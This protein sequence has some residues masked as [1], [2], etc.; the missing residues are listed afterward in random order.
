MKEKIKTFWEDL[1][2]FKKRNVIIVL[3]FLIP[4]III[5]ATI[6]LSP[7]LNDPKPSSSLP[8]SSEVSSSSSETVSS[9]EEVSSSETIEVYTLTL[10]LQG[11][12]VDEVVFPSLVFEDLEYEEIVTLPDEAYGN[13]TQDGFVFLGWFYDG[14]LTSEIND[15]DNTEL[16]IQ[17]SMIDEDT[18]LYAGWEEPQRNVTY[19]YYLVDANTYHDEGYFISGFT[20]DGP[21]LTSI[22]LPNTITDNDVTLPV[23]GLG[24][25]LFSNNI[26]L[27]TITLPSQLQYIDGEVFY[28]TAITSITLPTT[29]RYIAYGAFSASSIESIVLPAS[30]I[31]MEDSVF[32]DSALTSVTFALGF[33]L[34]YIP[35]STFR[36]SALTSINIPSSIL[37]IDDSAFEGSL[38]SEVN[39]GF[40]S[41][42][43]VIHSAAFKNTQLTS[44]TLPNSLTEIYEEAFFGTQIAALIIPASLRTLWRN[45]LSG[46]ASLA[47]LTF[48]DET[49]LV[50]VEGQDFDVSSPLIASAIETAITEGK[51]VYFVIKTTLVYFYENG[52]LIYMDLTIPEG[53]EVIADSVFEFGIFGNITFPSS[54]RYVQSRAFYGV[55]FDK[56][57]LNEGLK[58]IGYAAFRSMILGVGASHEQFIIPASVDFF[59]DYVFA[60]WRTIDESY[61]LVIEFAPGSPIT[62][63]QSNMFYNNQVIRQVVLPEEITEIEYSAFCNSSLTTINLPVGLQII[64]DRVF[65]G[66]PGLSSLTLPL[67]GNLSNLKDVGTNTFFNSGIDLQDE[68]GL[69]ILG[70]VIIHP[71][72]G[73]SN[74]VI[75]EGIIGIASSAFV[76]FGVSSLTINSTVLDFI[77]YYAFNDWDGFN[78]FDEITLPE[79]LTEVGAYAFN[80]T[81]LNNITLPSTLTHVGPHAFENLTNPATFPNGNPTFDVVYGTSFGSLTKTT[82]VNNAGF[83]GTN[84]FIEL[85]GT[86]YG[87]IGDS[88]SA[89]TSPTARSIVERALQDDTVLN[90][91][92]LG[93]GLTDIG[94]RAFYR[95]ALTSLSVPSTIQRIEEQAFRRNENLENVTFNGFNAIELMG[96]E[97]FDSTAYMDTLMATYY[98]EG[99]IVIDQGV[100]WGYDAVDYTTTITIPEGVEVIGV[101]SI[102]RNFTLEVIELPTTLLAIPDYFL[103][104]FRFIT[105]VDTQGKALNEYNYVGFQ[106]FSYTLVDHLLLTEAS[107]DVLHPLA[108]EDLYSLQT[109]LVSSVAAG[110]AYLASV[111][112]Y[113]TYWYGTFNIEVYND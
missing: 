66:T 104:Y 112:S 53:I 57:T 71:Y 92:T 56:L 103:D 97:A 76:G 7:G 111:T 74:V 34:N 20:V 26:D 58:G 35:E 52:A 88:S 93:E 90:E 31:G 63:I 98:D 40:S 8:S 16:G 13:I 109:L 5:P 64:D 107:L 24:W 100:L 39:F 21:T 84:G 94:Y 50:R 38:L 99:G 9:S 68:N 89:T 86:I 28:G 102:N 55:Y 6:L 54:M 83:T 23:V 44:I 49:S 80:G 46:M 29:L 113:F 1:K 105:T 47:V 95:G 22:T 73:D 41:R 30:I 33:Q 17:W 12:T 18:T 19:E 45:A 106:A 96:E 91:L 78:S 101:F 27:T 70:N 81:S 3:L 11:G 32:E 4:T 62:V 82:L 10:D 60:D 14:A 37:R 85:D 42:L 77:G 65:E 48:A 87:Y 108:L 75:P 61:I 110:E 51:H 69:N 67:D 36:N 79:G 25:G 43:H 59:E 15:E 72:T 2:L